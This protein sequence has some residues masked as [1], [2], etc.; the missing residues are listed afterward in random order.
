MQDTELLDKIE[1]RVYKYQRKQ[2]SIINN[3]FTIITIAIMSIVIIWYVNFIIPGLQDEKKQEQI[4][5][6]KQELLIKKHNIRL[7]QIELS[8][9]LNAKP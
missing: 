3:F 4:K 1:Q 5:L 6:E 9:R 2:S 7:E 8:K